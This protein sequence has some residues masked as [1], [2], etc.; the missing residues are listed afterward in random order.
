MEA[1]PGVGT[2]YRAREL[3]ETLDVWF[4]RPNRMG[5]EAVLFPEASLPPMPN[6]EWGQLGPGISG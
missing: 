3:E 4:Y 1:T 5:A 2:T 6:R